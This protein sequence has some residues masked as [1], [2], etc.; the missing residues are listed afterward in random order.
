MLERYESLVE[1]LLGLLEEA[2]RE[3]MG[4]LSSLGRWIASGRFDPKWT[5]AHLERLI[6]LAG[7]AKPY[8][9]VMGCLV[10]LVEAH[11]VETFEVFGF[12][13]NV[14]RVER[15]LILRRS[16]SARTILGTALANRRTSREA[17]ALI[18]R[19]GA[20]GYLGFRDLL[21]E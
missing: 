1:E 3:Q 17:R 4:H 7:T 5:L 16:E 18:D 2:G 19:L 9:D 11:P 8:V 6:R 13:V 20:C 10:E 15:R 21:K 12:W 14:D